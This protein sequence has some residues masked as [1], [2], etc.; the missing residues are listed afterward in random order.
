MHFSMVFTER[1]DQEFASS[2]SVLEYRILL[3]LTKELNVCDNEQY[4]FL[5]NRFISYTVTNRIYAF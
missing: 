1:V 5:N 3:K 2:L 4:G